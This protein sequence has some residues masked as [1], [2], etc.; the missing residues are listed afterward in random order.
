MKRKLISLILAAFCLCGCTT[1]N[2]IDINE[3]LSLNEQSIEQLQLE[4]IALTEEHLPLNFEAQHAIWFT[5]MDFQKALKYKTQ[6]EF[7]DYISSVTEKIKDSGFNTVYVHVRP[8]NS[9]Y[10]KSDIFPK[11]D[12]FPADF[13]AFEIIVQ[14]AH[15]KN[16]SVHGWINPLRCQSEE[17][18]KM[19]DKKY[20]IKK[21]YDEKSD[22][23]VSVNDR[24]YLNPAYEEVRKYISD[25]VTELIK[26]YSIDGVHIDDYFYPTTDESFDKTAFEKSK[27]TDLKKWRT[28]NINLTVKGIYNAVKSENKDML[29]GISP[30]G[31]IE[32]DKNNLYADVEKWCAESGYCDYIAPQLYYGFKNESKP[33]KETFQQWKS[34]VTCNDVKLTAGICVYKIGSEDKWAG[35]GKKEWIEDKN[36]PSRQLDYI[37]ENDYSAAIYSY[38]QLF[39]EKNTEELKLISEIFKEEQ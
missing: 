8:Y 28:E 3:S 34:A 12:D 14:K 32:I 17:E 37:F 6:E 38:G 5:M 22:Y 4:E 13:D 26:N 9:A 19:L 20:R 21:W 24:Y 18:I 10:Y 27:E 15:E 33:F 39:E 11:A 2:S 25:G 29:F 30:Q 16:L 23:I 1:E 7:T 35:S 36:I 31:N